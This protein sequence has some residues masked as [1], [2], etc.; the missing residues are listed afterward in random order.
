HYLLWKAGIQHNDP[1]MGNIGVRKINGVYRGVLNDWDLATV[2]GLSSHY[3]MERTGT[4]PFM[5]I[6]LLCIQYWEG[7]IRRLYRHDM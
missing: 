1:S 2:E 4:L 3:G 5:A 6:E 7:K